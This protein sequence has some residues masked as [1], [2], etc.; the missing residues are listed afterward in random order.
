[1]QSVIGGPIKIGCARNSTSRLA[2]LTR[3]SPVKL[4]LLASVDGGFPE[5]TLLHFIFKADRLHGEWFAPRPNLMAII[6]HCADRHEMP[7]LSAYLPKNVPGTIQRKANTPLAIYL[8]STGERQ[9]NFAKRAR[10]TDA[11]ISRIISG[12]IT[13]SLSLAL[14]IQ[15]AT[16]GKVKVDQFEKDAA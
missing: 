13:P 6:N 3:Y 2:E 14:R 12:N 11:T 15:R 5:E 10:S 8:R 1:M 16:G 4:V 9:T 7:D